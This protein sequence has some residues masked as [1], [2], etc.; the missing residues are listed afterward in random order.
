MNVQVVSSDPLSHPTPLLVLPLFKGVEE[1]EGVFSSADDLVGGALGRALRAGDFTGK[2]EE[3]LLLYPTEGS[4][5]GRILVIGLGE[6]ESLDAETL[7]RVAGRSVRVVEG[8]KVSA[9]SVWL[10]STW[11]TGPALS[12]QAATEG[13]VLAAWRFLELKSK[14]DPEEV[15]PEVA[16]SIAGFFAEVFEFAGE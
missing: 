3:T 15:G 14:D 1:P 16:R 7:R 12:A 10:D 11:S 4:G 6:E 5:I 13:C 8:L 9:L 2:A